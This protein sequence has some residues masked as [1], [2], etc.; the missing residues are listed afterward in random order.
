MDFES[1]A[2]H[3]HCICF[4][5]HMASSFPSDMGVGEIQILKPASYASENNKIIRNNT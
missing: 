3:T 2:A 4:L 1:K 5:T